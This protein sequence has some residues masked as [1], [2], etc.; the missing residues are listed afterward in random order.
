M[1]VPAYMTEAEWLTTNNAWR[2][3]MN[4]V[5]FTTSE[6]QHRLFRVAC[7]KGERRDFTLEIT[8][9]LE[10]TER[11]AD[12]MSAE[13][14]SSSRERLVSFISERFEP[15]H[16][17]SISNTT[18]QPDEAKASLIRCIFGSPTRIPFTVI[19]PS[20]LTSTVLTIANQ[21]YDSREFS[22]MPIL[23]DALQDADCDNERILDHCRQP[24]QHVQG[25]W[26]IDLLLAKDPN[27]TGQ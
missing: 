7:G 10:M 25:C 20:W 15:W 19:N 22:A 4:L 8:E 23:A 27:L 5:N 1:R 9:R 26:V 17:V 14:N 3:M 24:G 21:M 16:L 18:Q 13:G 11:L 6:R 2:M 12:Q